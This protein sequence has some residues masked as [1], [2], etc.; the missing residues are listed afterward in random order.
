MGI[1]TGILVYVVIWWLIFFMALPWGVHPA[2]ETDQGHQWGA[3]EQPRLLLKAAITTGIAT[4]AFYLLYLFVPA[5]ML[6][7]QLFKTS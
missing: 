5:D 2:E 3:P 4:V 1:V 7:W 6:Q